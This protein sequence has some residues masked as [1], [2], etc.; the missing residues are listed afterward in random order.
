MIEFLKKIYDSI[1]EISEFYL[2]IENKTRAH[3]FTVLFIIIFI[4]IIGILIKI[5]IQTLKLGKENRNLKTSIDRNI[6]G[7]LKNNKK[8][9]KV[10]NN[11]NFVD[12]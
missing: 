5:L 3:I 6:L 11:K 2:G 7:L 10:K 9:K 4:L 12:I 1:F 8:D